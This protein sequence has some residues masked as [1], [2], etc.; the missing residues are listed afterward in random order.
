[1]KLLL[2]PWGD[3]R[4]WTEVT[5]RL[6]GKV[7][8]GRTSLGL[9]EEEIGPDQVL[10]IV[11][12]TLGEG[13]TYGDVKESA[14]VCV[15]ERIKDFGLDPDRIRISVLP[16]TGQFPGRRFK[17]DPKDFYHTLLKELSE[18]LL[19]LSGDGDVEVHLDITHGINY[20][21]VLTYR[22]VRDL[23]GLLAA[24]RRVK[25]RVYNADPF[26]GGAADT[27][28]DV[29]V[30][31]DICVEPV[32][33]QTLPETGH[34]VLPA[35]HL[36]PEEKKV[37]GR[38]ISRRLRL[39]VPSVRAFLGAFTNGLP[40]ALC[41]FF[42]DAGD[43]RRTL[44]EAHSVFEEHTQVREDKEALHVTRRLRMGE[45]FALSV[46]AV[47]LAELIERTLGRRP[48]G[49]AVGYSFLKDL[50]D[51]VFGYDRRFRDRIGKDLRDIKEKAEEAGL[52]SGWKVLNELFGGQ[53]KEVDRR[54]FIAHSGFERNAVEV[55]RCEGE[56]YL[57][58]REDQR[59][60]VRD[61]CTAG[62]RLR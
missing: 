28:L 44:E 25:L 53:V 35:D 19:N 10:I 7:R 2:A 60:K 16:A 13:P 17:G 37:L 46:K 18:T 21:P 49:D 20:M 61:Y 58:Y 41:T 26:V 23:L 39:D 12:D 15:R 43:L 54:N 47:F 3:P 42:P 14:R 27:V 50:S 8:E 55:C 59:E 30:I 45:G 38:E 29:N 40:L 9:L 22:A 31:E 57:R 5:Y 1:M 34:L 52:G 33:L 51:K 24:F 4:R 48:P 11:G 6:G 36:S 62:P 32:P 56:I